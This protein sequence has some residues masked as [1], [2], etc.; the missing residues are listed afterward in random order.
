MSSSIFIPLLARELKASFFFIGAVI[1]SFNGLLFI[2]SLF[3]GFL[4]DRFE[5]R[6]FVCLGLFLSSILIFSHIFIKDCTL[7]FTIRAIS[8]FI[9]GIYPAALSVYGFAERDGMMGKFVG[10]GSLGWAFGSIIAGVI[11]SYTA[12]FLVGSL[13]FF[14]AFLVACS[15]K[16]NFS[17]EKIEIGALFD[18]FR[19]NIRLYI[20]Y[21]LRNLA[22]TSIWAIF[23]LFLT[24]LLANKFFI[25]LAYFLNTF[26]QFLITPWVERYK[27][28][29]LI[30]IG[31][32]ASCLVFLGYGLSP[33]YLYIL[34]IQ[35][36]LAFSY[37]TLQ[38]G[39][40]QE[41]LL[42]NREQS[43]ATGILFSLLNLSSVIGPFLAG[44]ILSHWDFKVL[45]YTS[46]LICLSSLFLF[47]SSKC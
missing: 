12:I 6:L 44:L 4:S 46:G 26:S 21:F 36:L 47:Y 19:R 23:P 40:L 29:L 13:L 27:N 37:S 24:S 17:K 2:S 25:A 11:Q 41:L 31:L 15:E 8:G 14:I 43:S 3:F 38:V 22:A 28:I 9:F 45:M 35:I 1:A 33:S 20:S 5:K 42:K 30:K 32:F 18:V 16:R 7:L 10:Y 34:P 39:C